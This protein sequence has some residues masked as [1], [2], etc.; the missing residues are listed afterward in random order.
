MTS[1]IKMSTDTMGKSAIT[2]DQEDQISISENKRDIKDLIRRQ[3][4]Q[5]T[6]SPRR[7]TIPEKKETGRESG[8]GQNKRKPP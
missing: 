5:K 7:V 3:N 2:T 8:R 1:E 6:G 4:M